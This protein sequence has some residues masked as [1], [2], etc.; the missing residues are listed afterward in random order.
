VDQKLGIAASDGQVRVSA[1]VT[2][3]ADSSVSATVSRRSG[4]VVLALIAIDG[5]N[6]ATPW[7]NDAPSWCMKGFLSNVGSWRLYYCPAIQHVTQP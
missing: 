1:I 4:C 2:Q 5:E 3:S 6:L 7:L